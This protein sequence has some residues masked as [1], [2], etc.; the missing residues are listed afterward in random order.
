MPRRVTPPSSAASRTA[1]VFCGEV[2]G[3]TCAATSP[4]PR[5]GAAA[6]DV[7]VH[8]AAAWARGLVELHG[9]PVPCAATLAVRRYGVADHAVYVCLVGLRVSPAW[10]AGSRLRPTARPTRA[11]EDDGIEIDHNMERGAA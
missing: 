7:A 2:C 11:V 9:T 1:C 10:R 5:L 6:V 3:S 4:R 8:Y